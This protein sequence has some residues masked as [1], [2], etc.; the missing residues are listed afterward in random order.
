MIPKSPERENKTRLR[1]LKVVS[2]CKSGRLMR[3]YGLI[4]RYA[5]SSAQS[6]Q[7]DRSGQ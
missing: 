7:R 6:K 4:R 3:G 5:V 1:K 2:S